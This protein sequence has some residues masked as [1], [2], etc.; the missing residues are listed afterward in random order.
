[1][2]SIAEV[3]LACED[4][5]TAQTRVTFKAKAQA[6]TL[7]TGQPRLFEPGPHVQLRRSYNE[8]RS[9]KLTDHAGPGPHYTQSLDT[10]LGR[11]ESEAESL[12]DVTSL[13]IEKA[14]A[15]FPPP[16]FFF[17]FAGTAATGMWAT[18]QRG[19]KTSLPQKVGACRDCI[20]C[21]ARRIALR[22]LQDP[23][24][25]VLATYT[26]ELWN[27]YLDRMLESELHGVAR[28]GR[29][30]RS[31][32][33]PP[34]DLWLHFDLEMRRWIMEQ[35]SE[36]YTF[37]ATIEGVFAN[38][39]L[40]RTEFDRPVGEEGARVAADKR[41]GQLSSQLVKA[42]GK[43]GNPPAK[44]TQQS[45]KQK[46]RRRAASSS[47]QQAQHLGPEAKRFKASGQQAN[48]TD[49]SDLTRVVNMAIKRH[50]AKQV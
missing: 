13:A 1:M 49:F 19:P 33:T 31:E 12:D 23:S 7:A 42:K 3:T 26:V 29:A 21:M 17:F 30:N 47:C 28:A 48:R 38:A 20:K 45:G 25:H 50:S 4:W 44:S 14:N 24:L 37:Q 22:Q 27:E 2:A 40:N 35:V 10:D 9:T 39:A 36:G 34:W 5:T 11:G 32:L 18:R 46:Q 41:C 16:P 6:E 8:T 43:G 15:A